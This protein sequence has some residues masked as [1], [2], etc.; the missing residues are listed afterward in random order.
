MHLFLLP[1]QDDEAPVFFE[2]ERLAQAGQ[3]I[4]VVYLTTGNPSPEPSPS[5]NAESVSVLSR[6]GVGAG[7]VVFLGDQLRIQDGLLQRHLD[8]A[9]EALVA[10][11]Q[12]TS[13]SI[14]LHV[15]A[16][17][18]GHHDHDAAY[19]LG[20]ALAQR[21]DCAANSHQFPY[22]HGYKL[23]GIL[24]KVLDPIDLNG[25]TIS[26]PIPWTKRIFYLRLLFTYRS[27]I[28]S[29]IG[30]GPFFVLHMLLRGTQ[31][32]QKLM[33]DRVCQKPHPSD[34]LY[35][36]RSFSSFPKFQS[37]TEEFSL[38]HLPELFKN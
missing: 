20:A 36:R 28:G 32:R 33:V 18:G 24:F 27:Q 11:L 22:Y 31:N 10:M 35:E 29:W 13:T 5:R 4:R 8:A 23:P 30:L 19:L 38:K 34:L 16:W 3:P 12:G 1:H 9:F 25:P 26:D 17:E 15:P 6:L 7:S 14:T 2:L 37:D 21:W